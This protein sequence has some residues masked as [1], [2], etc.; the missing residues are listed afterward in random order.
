MASVKNVYHRKK[1]GGQIALI[2]QSRDSDESGDGEIR[3]TLWGREKHSINIRTTQ[4]TRRQR[5]KALSLFFWE[6]LIKVNYVDTVRSND[7][8]IHSTMEGT[9]FIL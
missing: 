7:Y 6:S 8:T 2:R 5:V 9:G 4:A 1:E 3:I